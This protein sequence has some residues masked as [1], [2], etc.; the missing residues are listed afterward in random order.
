M[1]DKILEKIKEEFKVQPPIQ[2]EKDLQKCFDEFAKNLAKNFD[3][4]SYSKGY[5]KDNLNNGTIIFEKS[6]KPDGCFEKDN[7]KVYIE[8]K[9]L[10]NNYNDQ[11]RTMEYNTIR[12][13]IFQALT[14][15]TFG[16]D[17]ISIIWKENKSNLCSNKMKIIIENV[18]NW[19]GI[20]HISKDNFDFFILPAENKSSE[21]QNKSSKCPDELKEKFKKVINY[22]KEKIDLRKL[23]TR[24]LD[25]FDNFRQNLQQKIEKILNNEFFPNIKNNYH[26]IYSNNNHHLSLQCHILSQK[27]AGEGDQILGSNL[28]YSLLSEKHWSISVVLCKKTY[29]NFLPCEKTQDL[30]KRVWEK[31]GACWIFKGFFNNEEVFWAPTEL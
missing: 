25:N 9:P 8:I 31:T 23:E 15:T 12:D 16:D 21:S 17:A 10:L 13:G 27:S 5:L 11:S 30:V 26:Q 4:I 24:D 22:V 20:K 29:K 1:T 3:G 2:K 28:L 6:R 14:Y 19:L 7:E 18:H